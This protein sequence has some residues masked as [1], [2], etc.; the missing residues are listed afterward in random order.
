VGVAVGFFKAGLMRVPMSV[1]GPVV[2]GVAVLMC[3][4]VV[5]V[6]GVCMGMGYFTML[7]FV[8]VWRVMFV[9][10]GHGCSLLV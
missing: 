2:V 8:R 1:L 6:R 3:H 4:V 9:L 10:L 5:L 7:V